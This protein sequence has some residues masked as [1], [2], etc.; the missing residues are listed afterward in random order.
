M[1]EHIEKD[2][3]FLVENINSPPNAQRQL[4]SVLIVALQDIGHGYAGAKQ[5]VDDYLTALDKKVN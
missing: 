5:A 3:A 2:L 1:T 4:R